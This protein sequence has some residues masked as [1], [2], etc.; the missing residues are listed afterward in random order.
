MVNPL[1]FLKERLFKPRL[2]P[3]HQEAV[4]HDVVMRM[5]DGKLTEVTDD[6][7]EIREQE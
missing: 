5:I 1:L 6:D 4:D 2:E 7:L 3:E